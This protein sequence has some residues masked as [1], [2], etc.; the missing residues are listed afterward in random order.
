MLY[1]G[2]VAAGAAFLPLNPAYT[3]AELAYFLGGLPSRA[4]D[5]VRPRT[6]SEAIRRAGPCHVLTLGSAEGGGSLVE[7]IAMPP[8][9]CTIQSRAG[10]DDLAAIL[11][12]SGTTGRSKGA[13]ITHG[14][15]VSNAEALAEIWALHRGRP[16][17]SRAA[18]LSHPWACSRPI[19]TR[20]SSPAPALLFLPRFETGC[21]CSQPLPRATTMMGG[22]DL[23]HTP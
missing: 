8:T 11:Y 6:R 1:L 14:N 21:G 23:L 10:A 4:L 3:L 20:C 13:M 5:R 15:L 7:A 22:A 17:A 9:P 19:N 16:A 2:T 18:H 12:T